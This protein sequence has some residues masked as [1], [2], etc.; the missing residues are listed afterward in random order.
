MFGLKGLGATQQTAGQTADAVASWRRA[1]ASDERTRSSSS[2]TLYYLAGCHARLGGI[3]GT[4]GS[5]LSAAE[6]AA[7]LDRAMGVLRRAVAAGYRNVTWMKRDPDLDPLR[8]RPDFQAADDGP[9]VPV[10][11]V[12]EMRMPTADGV[13]PSAALT[14][15]NPAGFIF[16]PGHGGRGPLRNLSGA[17]SY[18]DR[19]SR[20]EPAPRSNTRGPFGTRGLLLGRPPPPIVPHLPIEQD[21]LGRIHQVRLPGNRL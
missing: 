18:S 8:A 13:L 12:L 11:P 21:I 6:G 9:G 4:A 2:E 17:C 1:V 7:E 14:D 15:D 3:A 5:G 10:R 19:S 20:S 16:G